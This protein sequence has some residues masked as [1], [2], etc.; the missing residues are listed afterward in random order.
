MKG[1]LTVAVL[2]SM[3]GVGS[4]LKTHNDRSFFSQHVRDFSFSFI[5][6][7]RT[8]NRCYHAFFLLLMHRVLSHPDL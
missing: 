5:S 7:V 4:A 1:K 3:P 2:D 6:P 8:Y